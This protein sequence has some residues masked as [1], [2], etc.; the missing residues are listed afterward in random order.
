MAKLTVYCDSELIDINLL[1]NS[2]YKTLKQKINL[3]AELTFCTA[4]EIRELNK[5]ERGKDAVTDV[6]SFPSTTVTAGE[7]VKRK[8]YPF[9]IDPESNSVFMGSIII[10]TER[11]KEQAEEY[12]HSLKREFYYLAVHGM[13][14][15]FGYDH[16]VESDKEV[17]REM[18][19][20][21][22]ALIGALREEV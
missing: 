14:H 16:E 12:G 15:I 6:L 20:E 10:C 4:E 5:N 1:A 3:S 22:L 17:M 19:E 2:V 11:A 9:D 8:N 18:E 7:I 13:L 21:I